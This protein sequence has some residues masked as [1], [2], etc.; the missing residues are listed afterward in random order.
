MA[1]E[2]NF[3]LS[4]LSDTGQTVANVS[5]DLRGRKVKDKDGN[6]VGLVGDMLID[7]RE[8]KVRFLLVEHGGFLGF[9]EEQSF[10]PVEAITQITAS[11]TDDVGRKEL[12]PL[13]GSADAGVI[14]AQ[15]RGLG[16]ARSSTSAVACA[17]RWSAQ[18]G[19]GR[20]RR[21]GAGGRRSRV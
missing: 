16:I 1:T 4:K 12:Q 9:G 13:G 5:V 14:G 3:M 19:A 21:R 8:H 10:I 2:G 7:E 6:D 15:S 20:T 11:R 18:P 17:T